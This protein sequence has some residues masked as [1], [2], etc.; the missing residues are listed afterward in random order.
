MKDLNEIQR[1][2]AEQQRSGVSM[3]AY[4]SEHGIPAGKFYSWKK[5]KGKRPTGF[6]RVQTS[7]TVQIE[8]EGAKLSVPLEAL[9]IVLSELAKR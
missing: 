4:C 5:R 1:H 7:I 8:I 2:L 3:A 9:N 6:A